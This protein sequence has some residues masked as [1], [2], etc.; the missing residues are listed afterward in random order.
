MKR[1]IEGEDRTQITLFPECIE[2]YVLD[3]NP[4]R[5]VDVF[6]GELDLDM[7]SFEGVAPAA[8]GRPAFHPAVHLKLCIYGST[9]F[10]RVGALRKRANATLS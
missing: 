4:V 2:D 7:L 6:V 1:F 9:A 10:S 8:T 5:V 3:T